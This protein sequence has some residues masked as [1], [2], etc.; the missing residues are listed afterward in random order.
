MLTSTMSAPIPSTICAAAAIFSGSPPKIWME[1]GRSSSVYSA[2]SRVRSIPRTSP[3]ALTISVTTRPQPPWRLTN[4]RNAESVIPA[5]GATAKG[6]GRSTVPMLVGFD[7][8][9]IDFHRDSLADQ[10]HGQDEPRAAL[11][12]THQP[13]NNAS[14]WAVDDLDHHAFVDQRARVVL[15]LAVDQQPDALELVVRN[16]G[17]FALERDYI[18][19]TR[20]LEDWKRVGRVEPDE[21]VARKERPIDF[22]LPILPAAPAA[23][24]GQKHFEALPLELLPDHL[25]VPRTR[26]NGIPL[27][28]RRRIESGF[29]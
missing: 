26:P 27:S 19:D 11:V 12:F 6:V 8:G 4:R 13:S 25:L 5:I 22:L 1:M 24:R 29:C 14:Q 16:R 20:A 10:V 17:R 15:Q 2:Y 21:A 23:D 3:S 28:R 9:G 7:V 18:D